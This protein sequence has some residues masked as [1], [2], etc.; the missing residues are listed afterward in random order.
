MAFVYKI[1]SPNNRIYVGSTMQKKIQNR[2]KGY[3]CAR[4]TQQVKICRSI[5]KYGFEN[6]K[7]EILWEGDISEMYKMES[8]YGILYNVLD[9]KK[10]LNCQ[11]PKSDDLIYC[12][13]EELRLQ[14][15]ISKKGKPASEIAKANMKLAWKNRV[16]NPESKSLMLKKRQEVTI[17]KGKSVIC[18]VSGQTFISVAR[19]SLYMG[20]SRSGLRAMLIGKYPNKTTLIYNKND[21]II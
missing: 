1:T 19:A 13:S 20:L 9:S 10:G 21:K 16:M 7:F 6:H 18:T 5:C 3:K 15:S 4:C 8:Y 14:R 11:L 2:W 12:I 17:I